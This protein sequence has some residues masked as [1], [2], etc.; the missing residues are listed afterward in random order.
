MEETIRI[1]ILNWLTQLRERGNLCVGTIFAREKVFHLDG[2]SVR[3][4]SGATG[5]GGL[6]QYDVVDELIP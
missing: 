1:V 3:T 6:S 4:D 5:Y 2:K